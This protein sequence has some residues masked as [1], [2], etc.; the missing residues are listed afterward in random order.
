MGINVITCT[1]LFDIAY[2]LIYYCYIVFFEGYAYGF[3]W[4]DSHNFPF[5][6][7]AIIL[8][9]LE[10]GVDCAVLCY[11]MRCLFILNDEHITAAVKISINV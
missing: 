5:I 1:N 6:L 7:I 3:K 9:V 4:S 10:I 8:F 2:V 11:A